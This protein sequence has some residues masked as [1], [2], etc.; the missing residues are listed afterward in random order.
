MQSKCLWHG[1]SIK[2]A[3]A[4]CIIYPKKRSTTYEQ[5]VK[6]SHKHN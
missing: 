2:K 3:S 4:S 5:P 1:S 6:G